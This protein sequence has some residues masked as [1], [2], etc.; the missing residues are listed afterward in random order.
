[1]TGTGGDAGTG[2]RPGGMGGGGGGMGGGASTELIAYLKKHR[3]GA[4]WL[5]AVSNS[6]SAAQL[7]LASKEPVISMWG[8]T[9]SD[10]AM[11]VAKLK[12][13]VKKGELHYIQVGGSG[14]GGGGMG[15]GN[16]VSSA[17]TAWVQKHGTVVKESAYSGS[18]ASNSSSASSDSASQ[19]SRS[20]IYR[21]D[22]SDAG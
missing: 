12:E 5:L 2:G 22:A 9:G 16:S 14:M 17:V 21:L 4:K 13:L 6:Q 18:T 7:V 15:G 3:D 1:P 10:K 11:T 19:S 8:F 20:T